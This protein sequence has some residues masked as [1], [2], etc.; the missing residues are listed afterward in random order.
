MTTNLSD[1]NRT[2]NLVCSKNRF[3]YGLPDFFLLSDDVRLADPVQTIN[4][5]PRNSAIILR[6]RDDAE[7]QRLAYILRPVCRRRYVLLFIANDIDLAIRCKADGIHCSE[8]YIWR[9]NTHLRSV[10][11][12]PA[13]RWLI[14]AAA[15]SL[16]SALRAQRT[17]VDM[18]LISPVFPTAS[19]PDARTLGTLQLTSITRRIV[20]PVYGLGGITGLR[21]KRLKNTGLAGLAGIEYFAKLLNKA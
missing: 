4:R 17:G 15:H 9:N 7:R 16:N 1:L 19:H 13:R 14:S 11:G 20:P 18:I 5:M 21:L 2:L 3:E 12:Q 10:A 8:A 6:H